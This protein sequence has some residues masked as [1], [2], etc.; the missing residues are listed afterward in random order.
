MSIPSTRGLPRM[1][2]P[3][4]LSLGIA[5]GEEEDEEASLASVSNMI[6]YAGVL[7]S[8]PLHLGAFL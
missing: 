4:V 2:G 1:A 6:Q 8:A 7:L 3:G 5:V